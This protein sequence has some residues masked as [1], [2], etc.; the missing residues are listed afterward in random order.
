M[1]CI[2]NFT[3]EDFA[4]DVQT[5]GIVEL[6]SFTTADGDEVLATIRTITSSRII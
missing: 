6:S 2:E 5:I 3:T 4:L 1:D